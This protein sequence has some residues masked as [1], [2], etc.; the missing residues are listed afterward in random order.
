MKDSILY[1]IDRVKQE[2]FINSGKTGYEE[3]KTDYEKLFD[4]ETEK[5][6][7]SKITDEEFK[8]YLVYNMLTKSSGQYIYNESFTKECEGLDNGLGKDRN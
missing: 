1:K 6:K 4:S 2:M 8:A 3:V 5:E 7:C